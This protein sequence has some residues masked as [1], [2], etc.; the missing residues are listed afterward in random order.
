MDNEYIYNKIIQDLYDLAEYAYNNGLEWETEFLTE[1]ANKFQIDHATSSNFGDG[2]TLNM[3]QGK[4][5]IARTNS[6]R[7]KY[8]SMFPAVSRFMPARRVISR[9]EEASKLYKY[10]SFNY[11]AEDKNKI[12]YSA[13]IKNKFE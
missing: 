4:L 1:Q 10:F 13:F 6:T 3:P 2:S 5:I 9:I 12:S 8:Y 7:F 11:S